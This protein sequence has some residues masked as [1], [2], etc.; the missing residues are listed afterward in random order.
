MAPRRWIARRPKLQADYGMPRGRTGMMAWGDVER[1][2][3]AARN[4]WVVTTGRRGMP[5][6]TPVWAVWLDDRLWFSCGRETLK[7]R[8]IAHQPHAHWVPPPELTE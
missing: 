3:V 7:A 6:A 5:Q 8:N 1:A 2:L 4:Y